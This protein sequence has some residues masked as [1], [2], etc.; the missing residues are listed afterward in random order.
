MALNGAGNPI[1]DSGRPRR[2]QYNLP[3][4]AIGVPS[5]YDLLCAMEK[6]LQRDDSAICWKRCT[7]PK[8]SVLNRHRLS[9][10]EKAWKARGRTE[11]SGARA[12]RFPIRGDVNVA[13]NLFRPWLR[14]TD[15]NKRKNERS[16]G[17]HKNTAIGGAGTARLQP[18]YGPSED[19]L[20]IMWTPPERKE[21]HRTS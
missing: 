16:A 8:R 20:L 6:N 5:N 14:R 13:K 10:T 15:L 9:K 18:L 19:Y 21:K 11:S 12:G 4:F 7:G 2:R 1:N 17:G 3:A